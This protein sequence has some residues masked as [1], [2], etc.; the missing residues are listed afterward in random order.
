MTF[1]R[2]RVVAAVLALSLFALVPH[3][4]GQNP[5][6]YG[7]G[8]QDPQPAKA[9]LAI[10]GGMLIDGHEGPPIPHALIL[11]DGNRIVAV[12][13]RDTLKVPPGTK[14]LDAAGMT[15]MPGLIDVHVHM[16]TIG[17]TDYQ[18]LAPDLQVAHPGHLRNLGASAA[19]LRRHHRARPRRVC[20]RPRGAQEEA[21]ERA[22]D[23]AARQVCDGLHLQLLR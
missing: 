5:R 12:G 1:Y 2:W 10:V 23:G 7:G 18:Y 6:R 14:V 22:A 4:G 16:D 20:S 9:T 3:A 8:D 13:T 19:D 11:I 15:V 17:H 21:R